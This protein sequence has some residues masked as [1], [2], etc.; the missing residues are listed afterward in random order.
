MITWRKVFW[1]AVVAYTAAHLGYSVV[2]YNIF[3]G[4]ASGDFNRV[5]QEATNWARSSTYSP[6]AGVWHPPFYYWF[7][8]HLDKAVGG[9]QRLAHALYFSQ[10]LLFPLAVHAMVKAARLEKRPAA[11][12]YM[13]AAALTVNFQPFLETLAQHK[14]EGIEF[15]LI[16]LAVL[17]YRQGRDLLCGAAVMLAAN[18][19]YLPGI[20]ILFFLVKR[21]WRVLLG[22]LLMEGAIVLLLAHS[23]GLEVLRFALIQHP[24]DLLFSHRHEGTFPL[25][26][27]EMQTLAGT[28]NRLLARPDPAY[29]FM[30]YIETE[31]YMPVSRPAL[32][33]G[34]A[35]ALRL[36]LIGVWVFF[37]RRGIPVRERER[38]WPRLLLELSFTLVMLLMISQLARVHY[39][40]LLL[41]AFVAVGLLLYQ[42]RCRFRPLERW[43]FLAAYGL[44]AMLIPGGFLNKLPPAPLWGS[45]YSD[46]YLWA[47]L[48]FIGYVLLG[49]CILLCARRLRAAPPGKSS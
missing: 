41:P 19:K 35:G 34:I 16:A 7:L 20:L 3:S 22:M 9:Q 45:S 40:I 5:Y 33:Q 32:A 36:L 29:G 8:L 28:V 11:M 6:D 30:Y 12:L 13:A 24:A 2:R 25:A 47:S 48:P 23:Y 26:S 14:V 49:A 15:F 39:G 46:L 4:L 1:A 21:Q 27:V 10:F 17:W 18:L 42:W 44:S 37:I 31:N 38:A 43:L